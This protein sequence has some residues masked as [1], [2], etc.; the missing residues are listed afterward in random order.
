LFS[1]SLNLCLFSIQI[2]LFRLHRHRETLAALF[3]S[4][5]QKSTLFPAES[6]SS[7]SSAANNYTISITIIII[8]EQEFSAR[9][10]AKEQPLG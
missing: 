3:F 10:T 5:N 2:N 6:S 4:S 8:I 7:S 1:F 9:P